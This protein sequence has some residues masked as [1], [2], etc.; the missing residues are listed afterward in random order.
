ME[1]LRSKLVICLLSL[2]SLAHSV[3]GSPVITVG[4]G[5]NPAAIQPSVDAFR[6]QL[7]S[8][9]PNNGQSFTSGRREI[10]WDGVPD[11][12]AEPNAFPF[13]FFNVNSPRG[14]VFHSI[15]NIGGNHQF[16]VSA[17]TASGTA[18]RF[19]NLDASYPTIFQAFSSER[20]FHG[21]FANEIEI[22]FFIPG[23]KIPATVS[24]F[25]AVFCDVDG[26]NTFIEYYAPDGSKISGSSVNTFNN[27]LSFLGTFFN[28]GE[29]VAK[30]IIRLGN[31]NL[32]SGNVDGTNG[33]DVAA[34]DD[35]IYGEPHA[36]DFHTGD[37]DGD[38]VTDSNIFRPP[39]GQWF[40]LNSG[41]NTASIVQWGQNGDIPVDG[42]F[43]GD[44]VA[45][46]AIF[47]PSDG[48]WWIH[49]STDS[50]TIIA[51]FGANGDKPVTGDYD[52]DG[53]T[54]IAFW[55]PSN[56]NFFIA[57]SSTGFSTFF[58]Y[59]FGQAGDIPVQGAAQ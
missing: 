53:K 9:N 32:Q 51:V 48:S 1:N 38:G 43:D 3:S 6:L 23:T 52:K 2:I 15:A 50:Q 26:S 35:F 29:R 30:V 25:G 7:G 11:S 12:F 55:R 8:L 19:G 24:G 44:R 27:G 36:L 39:T 17:S 18:V 56:G 59:G 54:D 45:D 41:T 40:I 49:K 34:M 42:D 14:V 21:R 57:R 5:S 10:N 37:F 58:G 16:R 13:D 47:R 20:I 28:A 4:S 33:I 22:L 46:Q 31:A